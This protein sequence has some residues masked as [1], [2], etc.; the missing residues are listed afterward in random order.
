MGVKKV[1]LVGVGLIGGS[2]A[3]ALRKAYPDIKIVGYHP[4]LNHLRQ[5]KS[6]GI[7]D[8]STNDISVLC[9][10]ADFIF[11]CTPVS[12]IIPTIEKL[13]AEVEKQTIVTDVGSVKQRIVLEAEK[14][15]KGKAQFIGG[16]PMAG[17]E[18]RGVNSATESLLEGSVYILTPTESTDPNAFE[19]LHGLIAK[20][21]VKV[22]AVSAKRHDEIVATVSH[23][24]H[25]LASSL[26]NVS[27]TSSKDVERVLFF[28]AGGFRDATRIAAGDPKLWNDICMENRKAIIKA[29]DLFID[30]LN[31]VQHS[32]KVQDRK[33]LGAKLASAQ[34][35][36][37]SLTMVS[38]VEQN[39][40]E[41]A[42]PVADKPGV[43]STIAQT[44]G[45]SGI[46]IEDIQ[47]VHL[48]ERRG[49]V[50][51]LVNESSQLSQA[52]KELSEAGFK[53]IKR[54]A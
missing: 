24:P 10:H 52:M 4:R 30:Q 19:R 39:L 40:Q 29:L 2:I 22:V 53:A 44:L 27:V 21:G 14:I 7:I 15:L 16:H 6:L 51:L 41:I 12:K 23:L 50:R 48:S 32:L 13:A 46:N 8:R 35:L 45:N 47:L 34:K 20:L 37:S 1:S 25:L 54:K 33:T 26:V 43:I 18:H 38:K 5:A 28:A 42:I 17:S 49:L 11:I 36:R 9:R 3:L 31:Q